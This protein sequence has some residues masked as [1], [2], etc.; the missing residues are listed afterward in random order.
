VLN[1]VRPGEAVVVVRLGVRHATKLAAIRREG[2]PPAVGQAG[3]GVKLFIEGVHFGEEPISGSPRDVC[4]DEGGIGGDEAAG[5]GCSE[6]AG[7]APVGGEES[8]S[9]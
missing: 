7:G 5:K 6:G 3:D 2:D 8:T 9:G 4:N 1:G